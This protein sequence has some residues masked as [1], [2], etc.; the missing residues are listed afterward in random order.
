MK[1]P[2]IGLGHLG[3]LYWAAVN[4]WLSWPGQRDAVP[5]VTVEWMILLLNPAIFGVFGCLGG[6]RGTLRVGGLWPLVVLLVWW[7]APS[8]WLVYLGHASAWDC[9]RHVLFRPPLWY[10]IVYLSGCAGTWAICAAIA[11]RLRR[12]RDRLAEEERKDRAER[13]TS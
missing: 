1:R 5:V 2:G 10:S 4:F 12:R 3:G 11:A 8:F 6:W 13:A 9:F 7:I